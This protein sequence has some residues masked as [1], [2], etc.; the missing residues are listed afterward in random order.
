VHCYNNHFQF[1]L[2]KDTV[3][4]RAKKYTPFKLN[5]QL[6]KYIKRNDKRFH[7]EH[8]RFH[9]DKYNCNYLHLLDIRKMQ[10]NIS[11]VFMCYGEDVTLPMGHACFRYD[12]VVNEPVYIKI[13]D[14]FTYNEPS[15]ILTSGY[16][17]GGTFHDGYNPDK[18]A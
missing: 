2:P 7:T 5:I 1:Y 13:V 12:H 17:G 16:H 9:N 4:S 6:K 11:G 8:I 15:N 14:S 18:E 3:L 10:T